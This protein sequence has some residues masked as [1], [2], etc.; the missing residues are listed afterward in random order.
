MIEILVIDNKPE[1]HKLG[2]KIYDIFRTINGVEG[3]RW[4]NYNRIDTQRGR[5]YGSVYSRR[6]SRKVVCNN[7]ISP[8]YVFYLEFYCKNQFAHLRSWEW[9]SMFLSKMKCFWKGIHIHFNEKVVARKMKLEIFNS[10]FYCKY[11]FKSGTVVKFWEIECTT[12]VYIN[13]DI[14]WTWNRVG[15]YMN[16]CYVPRQLAR[17]HMT[18]LFSKTWVTEYEI[19]SMTDLLI[20]DLKERIR[21]VEP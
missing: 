4:K 11:F 17:E 13:M 2:K 12:L 7:I 5:N 9:G 3:K 20:Q 21:I 16:L 14:P 6:I 10:M 18:S 1:C 15:K 8:L 19:L